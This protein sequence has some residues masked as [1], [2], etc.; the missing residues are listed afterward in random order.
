MAFSF[1]N[2]YGPPMIKQIPYRSIK[3]LANYLLLTTII[4]C[5]HG[6]NEAG[7]PPSEGAAGM[8]GALGTFTLSLENGT[9]KDSYW[10][11]SDGIAPGIAG[12]HIGTNAEG[13]PNQ[14]MFGEYCESNV[15]LVESNPAK[16]KIHLHKDDLGHP[17]RFDCN[18]WCI[19]QGSTKGQFQSI[20][21]EPCGS[22]AICACE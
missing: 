7:K 5:G 16:D 15:V 12:C 6:C 13:E 22:S 3:T 8:P 2:Q 19:G 18:A 9:G 4:L 10:I 20:E 1:F 14:R 11:D 17:D 21:I